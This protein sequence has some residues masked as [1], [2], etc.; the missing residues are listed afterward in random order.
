VRSSFQGAEHPVNNVTWL[1][2]K[3]YC[4]QKG[5]RLPT[6]AEW[7]YAARGVDGWIYPWGN[8][9]HEDYA[10]WNR[11]LTL[12]PE[13]RGSIM[14][15][16]SWVGAR[17]M[18]GNVWEWTSSISRDYPY[19]SDDG[20]EALVE[21]LQSIRYVARGGAWDS[22][23]SALLHSATRFSANAMATDSSIGFRCVRDID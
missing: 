4:E 6:E 18:A 9:W 19:H 5:K 7:E 1:E 2:A 13:N 11:D 10:I 12:G 21:D 22:R 17:D 23:D 15:G 8:D 16:A 3:Q 14:E 20:R